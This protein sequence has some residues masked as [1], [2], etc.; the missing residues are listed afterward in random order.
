MDPHHTCQPRRVLHDSARS[1][2]A[3]TLQEQYVAE[4]KILMKSYNDYLGIKEA[5]KELLLYAAGNEALPLLKKQ[6][7]SFGDSMVLSMIN[8]LRLKIVIKIATELKHKYKTTGYNN[9][10]DPT[11]SITAYFTQLD[12]LVPDF[13]WQLQHCDKQC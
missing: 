7:I 10:W 6:Y 9:P 13:T 2:N 4:H 11:T 3:V 8:H 12:W 1:G 5:G